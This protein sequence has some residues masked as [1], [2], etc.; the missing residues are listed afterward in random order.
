MWGGGK[1]E[2]KEQYVGGAKIVTLNSYLYLNVQ[3]QSYSVQGTYISLSLIKQTEH[4][5]IDTLR[6]LLFPGD[7]VSWLTEP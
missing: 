3:L 7:I 5:T 2:D 1:G 6:T 4:S